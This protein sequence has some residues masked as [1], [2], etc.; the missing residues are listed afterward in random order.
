MNIWCTKWK[1]NQLDIFILSF[2]LFDSSV[3]QI[4]KLQTDK[5][6]LYLFVIDFTESGGKQVLEELLLEEI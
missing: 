3:H 4:Y 2:L 1:V 5:A 6:Y